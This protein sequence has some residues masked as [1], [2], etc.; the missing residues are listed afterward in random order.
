[1][2]TRREFNKRVK[3]FLSRAEAPDA[4]AGPPDVAPDA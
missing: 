2:L 3:K 4:P 1:M